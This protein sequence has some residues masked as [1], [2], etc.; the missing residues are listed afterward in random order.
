MIMAKDKV[1][2][3]RDE[4]MSQMLKC[5]GSEEWDKAFANRPKSEL[6]AAMGGM[7]FG[8]MYAAVHT[9]EYVVPNVRTVRPCNW[10]GECPIWTIAFEEGSELNTWPKV[11][12]ECV[13][14]DCPCVGEDVLDG[15]I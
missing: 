8:S 5:I 3:D 10:C 7:A 4:F 1:Y 15:I 13:R 12:A 6:T 14:R 2:V 9:K 11:V